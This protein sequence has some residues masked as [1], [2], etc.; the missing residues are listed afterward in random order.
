MEKLGADIVMVPYAF[1]QEAQTAVLAGR[2]VVK[3]LIP[4]MQVDTAKK[5]KEVDKVSPQLYLGSVTGSPYCTAGPMYVF[6]FEPDTDFT[7]LPWLRGKL[8]APLGE[9]EAIGGTLVSLPSDASGIELGGRKLKLRG[10]LES[11]GIWLDQA[12]FVTFET[13]FM[14][15]E[16]SGLKS[17]IPLGKARDFVSTISIKLKRGYSI[18]TTATKAMMATGAWPVRSPTLPRL[19]ESQRAGLIQSLLVALGVIWGLAV[20]LSGLVFSLIVGERRREIGMLR[21]VG[22]S[23]NFI[24]RL[25]LTESALLAAVGGV[26]GIVVSLLFIYLLQ[27]WLIATLELPFLFPALPRL[28]G[29]M[30]GCLVIALALALPALLYPAVKASRLDPSVAMREV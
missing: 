3:S 14:L 6:A 17:I 23:R 15:V 27:S 28:I 12:L 18:D 10:S 1:G 7:V 24:F 5:M 11:T 29:F 20:V 16:D 26:A 21:A 4:A 19:L 25:F 2:P 22:A 13:G 30:I 9:D 8:R